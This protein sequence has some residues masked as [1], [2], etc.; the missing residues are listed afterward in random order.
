MNENMKKFNGSYKS[1]RIQCQSE[2]DYMLSCA[3]GS[4]KWR[5]NLQK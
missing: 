3:E 5:K 2:I 1:K 4:I